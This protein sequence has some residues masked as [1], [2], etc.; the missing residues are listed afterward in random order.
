MITRTGIKG[1]LSYA[2]NLLRNPRSVRV[3]TTG[4][5]SFSSCITAILAKN[6]S[7]ARSA[8]DS[9]RALCCSNHS[10]HFAASSPKSCLVIFRSASAACS[11][12]YVSETLLSLSAALEAPVDPIYMA[13]RQPDPYYLSNNIFL[14]CTIGLSLLPTL[15]AS[16]RHK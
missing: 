6:A 7:F 5:F 11:Q 3:N 2:T 10:C 8:S 13:S 1:V 9:P 12:T 14:A 15:V 16:I 4:L